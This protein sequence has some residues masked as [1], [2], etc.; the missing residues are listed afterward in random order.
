MEVLNTELF[1]KSYP[2]VITDNF[3][4]LTEFLTDITAKIVVI[5]DSNVGKIYSNNLCEVINGLCERMIY[6][7]IPAGEESK[8]ITQLSNI[9]HFLIENKINRSDI[10]IG[11][12]GGVVGD[13]V[14]FVA[15]TYLRGIRLIHMPTSL[16]SQVDS[17]IGGKT[18]INMMNVKN[19]VG[20]FYQPTLVY[21]NYC[22]LDSLPLEERTNGFVEMVVHAII[23]DEKLF[24]ILENNVEKIINLDKLIISKVI[25]RNCLIKKNVIEADEKETG[26]RVKLN[27]GH[28]F[29]HAIE[30]SY[31]YQ[32]K[33]GE[34]VASGILGACYIGESL[35]I[36]DTGI[37][38]R[39]YNLLKKLGIFR[40]LSKCKWEDVYQYMQLDKKRISNQVQ[41]IIPT[42][43]GRVINYRVQDIDVIKRAFDRMI[44]IPSSKA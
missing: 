29:G 16:L 18:A 41:F 20:A 32:Y 23:K 24:E 27:F 4:E 14:G 44:K 9:Y 15:A 30:S 36:L 37:T 2:I 25:T 17:C 42:T 7:E 31:N 39:I 1:D 22:V 26:E 8:S 5:S 34:C 38:D 43:I 13:L 33:H 19:V 3:Y 10:I 12:G 40:E 35:N 11:L 28:T 6:Y 21:I